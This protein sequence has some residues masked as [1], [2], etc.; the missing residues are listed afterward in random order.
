MRYRGVM[1]G[2]HAGSGGLD[3]QTVWFV[4]RRQPCRAH[5]WARHVHA[6]ATRSRRVRNVDPGNRPVLFRPPFVLRVR[7]HRLLVRSGCVPGWCDLADR[8]YVVELWDIVGFGSPER[9]ARPAF[10]T[11]TCDAVGSRRARPPGA[12]GLAHPHLTSTVRDSKAPTQRHPPS[13]RCRFTIS[14]HARPGPTGCRSSGSP[15][16]AS[17]AASSSGR[18]DIG[19]RGDDRN[20]T[21]RRLCACPAASRCRPRGTAPSA[22]L[23]PRPERPRCH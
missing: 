8:G 22:R 12:R 11:W 10:G 4:D 3:V 7:R 6:R 1:G 23:V 14:G 18:I 15:S 19:G 13:C 16:A 2:Q 21:G 17:P 9:K 20:E 5:R